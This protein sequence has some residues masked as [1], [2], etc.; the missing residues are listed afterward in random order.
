MFLLWLRWSGSGRGEGVAHLEREVELSPAPRVREGARLPLRFTIAGAD[1][2]GDVLI[3]Q[4]PLV[5]A[6]G[7]HVTEALLSGLDEFGALPP[8]VEFL[9][10]LR[11]IVDGGAVRRFALGSTPG[12]DT[13]RVE[14]VLV[15][16]KRDPDS[17]AD[18]P[19]A[20][21]VAW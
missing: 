1:G 12:I 13:E 11:P 15:L 6:D 18:G 14:A 4:I 16:K 3:D 2:D 9:Y 19:T 21:T 20:E 5:L 10:E 8:N 7:T 17:P